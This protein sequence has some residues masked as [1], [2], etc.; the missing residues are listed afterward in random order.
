MS[1]QENNEPVVGAKVII[2]G[3]DGI[4]ITRYSDQNG[5]IDL[6]HSDSICIK[7]G[8]TYTIEIEGESN[9]Y[10]GTSDALH[11]IGINQNT[12]IIR[13][14]KVLNRICVLRIPYLS[15]AIKSAELSPEMCDSLNYIKDILVERTNIILEIAAIFDQST[16]KK[17]ATKRAQNVLNYLTTFGIPAERFKIALYERTEKEIHNSDIEFRILSFDYTPSNE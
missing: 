10:Q 8:H 4:S 12:R 9:R 14:L 1:D 17:L 15:F 5:R 2:N 16:S 13:D 3:S 6:L 7:V 11:T